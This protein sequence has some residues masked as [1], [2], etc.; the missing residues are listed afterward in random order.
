MADHLTRKHR[1]WNMSRITSRHSKPEV[2]IRSLL[3]RAGY[4]FRI[5]NKKLP[6]CPDIVL[7]KYNTV[8]FV[9]GCFWHRHE[10]CPKAS[11]PGTNAEYWLDKFSKNIS[12]DKKNKKKLESLGWNVLVVWECEVIKNPVSVIEKIL[13]SDV[14]HEPS[15]YSTDIK[16]SI[17]LKLAEKRSRYL[18]NRGNI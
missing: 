10:G 11:T 8:I 5:N 15:N 18:K 7:N 6:G 3:H 9:H 14:M 12:R 1:S 17:I 13:S 4:R 2:I 16:R